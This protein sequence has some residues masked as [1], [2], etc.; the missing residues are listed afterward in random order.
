MHLFYENIAKYMLEHWLGIFFTDVSE[1]HEPYVI[2]KSVWSDIGNQMHALRKDLPS[3]LGRPLRNILLHYHGYKAEEWAAWI[4]MYS[5]PLLRGR[6][7]LEYYNGWSLFVKA[8]KLCQKKI[9]TVHD[10][11]N[12]NNLLLKFYTHY[13][14]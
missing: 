1:N 5:L 2:A 6:L 14:K 4:T 9:I 3:N 13:E 10:L 12:I 7:P 11:D 8:V